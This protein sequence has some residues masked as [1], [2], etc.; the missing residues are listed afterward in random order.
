MAPPRMTVRCERGWKMAEKKHR[1]MPPDP[2]D[3]KFPGYPSTDEATTELGA[4]QAGDRDPR[5]R[6]DDLAGVDALEGEGATD[7]EMAPDEID[8]PLPYGGERDV[9]LREFDEEDEEPG[10]RPTRIQQA[11]GTETPYDEE[12]VD[13]DESTEQL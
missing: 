11:L 5:E 3:R 13:W 7:N 8:V 2:D 6:A 12:D 10:E 9:R 1:Q 4:E